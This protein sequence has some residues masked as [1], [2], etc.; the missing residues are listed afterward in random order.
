[1]VMVEG[2]GERDK[3]TEKKSEE[4]RDLEIEKSVAVKANNKQE[5]EN[6]ELFKM[7]IVARAR[8]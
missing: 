7:M 4:V 8:Y 1:M 3:Q 5:S 2:K 6:K